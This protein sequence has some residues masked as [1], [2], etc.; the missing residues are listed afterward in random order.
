MGASS[1]LAAGQAAAQGYYQ[2]PALGP[3]ALVFASEG[4][5][6]R[7]APAGGEALRLTTHPEAESTP[8]ISPDGRWIAFEA[9]Y[10]GPREIYLMPISGR[11]G[12]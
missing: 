10:D 3:D 2:T 8:V 7:S 12:R 9:T 11:Q 4:D 5:L 1:L 6:W